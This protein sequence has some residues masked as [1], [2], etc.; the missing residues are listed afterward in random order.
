VIALLHL[1]GDDV[2]D[3][4]RAA[5]DSLARC[6]GY[7]RGRIGR[8]PDD[9]SDWLLLTEW[10]NVGSY[11]RALGAYQVK[12]A[13]TPLTAAARD[14]PGAFETLVDDAPDRPVRSYE[15]NREPQP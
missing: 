15:S 6:P 7:V 2:A 13:L 1:V 3:Q 4:A 9:P 5:L 12:L 11:R 10:T 8:S 14:V